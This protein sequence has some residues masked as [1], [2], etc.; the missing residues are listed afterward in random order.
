MKVFSK[1]IQQ[2]DEINEPE[3]RRR[4]LED[5]F[6]QADDQDKLW[7]IAILTGKRPKGSVKTTILKNWAIETSDIDP[8]LFDE[9]Y[10]IVGDLA[11]TISL[12]VKQEI[13]DQNKSLTSYINTITVIKAS[14]DKQKEAIVISV[15]KE[16]EFYGRFI[17]NKLL[18]GGFRYEISLKTICTT[19]SK[20]TGIDEKLLAH[21]FAD[22]WDP[23]ADTFEDILKS[24]KETNSYSLPYPSVQIETVHSDLHELGPGRRMVCRMEMERNKKSDDKEK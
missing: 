14:D 9:S 13:F 20:S 8:W 23:Y 19:L 5:Y 10:S 17:F 15:W 4:A 18:T 6:E 1:L 3:V 21:R 24:A 2:I 12:L 11:E 16:L 22:H 7:A